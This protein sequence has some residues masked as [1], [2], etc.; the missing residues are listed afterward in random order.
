MFQALAA[1]IAA[2]GVAALIIPLPRP[3]GRVR[4]PSSHG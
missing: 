2:T 3:A 1:L 4:T